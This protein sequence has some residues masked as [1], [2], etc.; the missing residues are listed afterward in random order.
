MSYWLL[1]HFSTTGL[2]GEGSAITFPPGLA[3]AAS[4]HS[5]AVLEDVIDDIA[6]YEPHLTVSDVYTLGLDVARSRCSSFPSIFSTGPYRATRP[7]RSFW[8]AWL[9]SLSCSS[10]AT[11][12]LGASSSRMP[13]EQRYCTYQQV[14]VRVS[15]MDTPSQSRHSRLTDME[16][17][18]AGRNILLLLL[19][20]V[21]PIIL[22]AALPADFAF[23]ACR[24]PGCS[25][26]VREMLLKHSSV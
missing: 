5:S 1:A 16:F 8:I 22:S 2:A 10:T 14:R 12:A 3:A 17:A 4:V 21:P 23:A 15:P 9:P 26:V 25:G 13:L 7:N 19:A 6:L 11:T 24:S 20:A 18:L